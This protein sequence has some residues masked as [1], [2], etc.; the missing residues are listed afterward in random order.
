MQQ[1]PYMPDEPEEFESL[2][3][4]PLPESDA[5][6]ESEPESIGPV[7]ADSLSSYLKEI[8]DIPVLTREEEQALARQM[9]EGSKEAMDKL[10]RS[11]LKYVVSV[12]N[13]YKGCGLS[14]LDLI[15]EGNIGLIQAAKRFDPDKGVKFI[16]YAVWWIRQSIMHA[17]AEQSGTVRLPI[18]QAGKL[19]KI[20]EKY[21]ELKQAHGR[22]PTTDELAKELDQTEEEIDSILRVYRSH[23]SLD[24]PITEGDDTSYLDLLESKDMP[25]VE[26]SLV[27]ASLHQIVEELL[28]ELSPRE[29][30][31]LRLRFGF[32]REPMKLEDIQ[33]ELRLS[34][35]KIRSRV[36]AVLPNLAPQEQEILKLSFGLAG[37][38][39]TLEQVAEKLGIRT[40]GLRGTVSS[41]LEKLPPREKEIVRLRFGLV[42]G[43]PMTL[44]EIGKEIGLSR[45]RIRQIE[46]KAKRRLRARSRVKALQD[47]LN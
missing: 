18:K 17:L 27:R 7:T 31:I 14:L 16:T 13:K 34:G 40:E 29:R 25:S 39:M 11:N 23:L 24:A 45:E 32:E 26:E 33:K 44:E 15:N 9:I 47:Y 21:Q 37:E 1:D 36:G 2:D 22:E 41:F 20:G 19:Y 42:G 38:P 46:K 10:I 35:E 28:D 6:P 43:E 4:E 8:R 5:L 30:Q 3:E 12:A